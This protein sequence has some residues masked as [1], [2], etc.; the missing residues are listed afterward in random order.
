[1]GIIMQY[2]MHISFFTRHRMN[3]WKLMPTIFSSLDISTFM[4]AAGSTTLGAHPILRH[5]D[6]HGHPMVTIGVLLMIIPRVKIMMTRILPGTISHFLLS[7]RNA[8][9]TSQSSPQRNVF[10]AHNQ[11]CIR[12][13]SEVSILP[14]KIT[15]G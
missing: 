4:V 15:V 13:P 2:I 1:M 5:T 6:D 14:E 3:I 10:V 7:I 9:D 11:E 8:R 12:S